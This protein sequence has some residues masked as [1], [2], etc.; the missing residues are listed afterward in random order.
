MNMMQIKE[1][2]ERIIARTPYTKEEVLSFLTAEPELT[3][4]ELMA[5]G[6]ALEYLRDKKDKRS[7]NLRK[8]FTKK[9]DDLI[10]YYNSHPLE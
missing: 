7:E 6:I 1:E 10:T 3:M 9:K 5:Y 8:Q 2:I 4:D